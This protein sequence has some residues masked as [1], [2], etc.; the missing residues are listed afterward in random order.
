MKTLP[1]FENNNNNNNNN[2]NILHLYSAFLSYTILNART[3]PTNHSITQQFQHF[4][5]NKNHDYELEI[6]SQLEEI[7]FE[8]RLEE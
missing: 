1:R 8:T 3:L 6:K 5:N 7:G 2:N 4:N